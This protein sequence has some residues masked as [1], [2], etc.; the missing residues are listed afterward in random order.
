LGDLERERYS[1]VRWVVG[2]AGAV[3]PGSDGA[4]ACILP[5]A[6][7][8][9]AAWA[10]AGRRQHLECSSCATEHCTALAAVLQPS[11]HRARL[12]FWH[13]P[14]L[15]CVQLASTWEGIRACETL[16]KQGIDCNMTLLFS[17]AQ[18]RARRSFR[19]FAPQSSPWV[20]WRV[21]RIAALHVQDAVLQSS[22]GHLPELVCPLSSTG[23]LQIY[24]SQSLGA[25]LSCVSA[26]P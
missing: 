10:W 4:D 7:Q 1:L 2:P 23:S 9:A 25:L 6:R 22:F 21:V 16:Q 13:R 24:T 15:W 11:L 18:V 26:F 12:T 14:C 5:T 3:E 19:H 20:V 17:F 8:G